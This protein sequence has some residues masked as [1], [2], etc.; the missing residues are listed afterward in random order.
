MCRFARVFSAACA[1]GTLYVS[2]RDERFLLSHDQIFF[3]S[4]NY[5]SVLLPG[6]TGG[7]PGGRT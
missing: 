3:D 1:A 7:Q 4:L 2:V 6:A 5:L